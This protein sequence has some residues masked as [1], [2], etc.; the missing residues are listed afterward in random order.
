MWKLFWRCRK[1]TGKVA[2]Y[3]GSTD[4]GRCTNT[5]SLN[6][7]NFETSVRVKNFTGKKLSIL[8]FQNVLAK[9]EENF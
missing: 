8:R 7:N 3:S 4:Y 1:N 5:F 2:L 6:V 9:Y